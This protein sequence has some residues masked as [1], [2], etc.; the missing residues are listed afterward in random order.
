MSLLV[1]A[2][3]GQLVSTEGFKS[4]APDY[5]GSGTPDFICGEG[6]WYCLIETHKNSYYSGGHG[7][8][9][10]QNVTPR[11]AGILLGIQ[12]KAFGGSTVVFSVGWDGNVYSYGSYWAYQNG[13][14]LRNGGSYAAIYGVGSESM[15]DVVVGGIG[16]HANKRP[17]FGVWTGYQWALRV[18]DDAAIIVGDQ[19]LKLTTN[20]DALYVTQELEDGGTRTAV[21]P[22]SGP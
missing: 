18:R 4:S 12:N 7:D 21:I 16:A 1:L 15:P 19:V 8:V 22:W 6:D 20:N 9:S 13:G 10:I 2:L 5:N 11:Y 14:G 17:S 3:L